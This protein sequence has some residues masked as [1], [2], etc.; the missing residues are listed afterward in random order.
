MLQMRNNDADTARWLDMI[1]ENTER[2][3]ALVQQVLTFARGMSGD[4]VSVS[5]KHVI[6][7]IISV[8]GQ[9]LPKSISVTR[10]IPNELWTISADPTQIHQVLTNICINARDA[11]PSGGTINISANNVVLD[12]DYS[13]MN[14]D[15]APGPYVIVTITD[16][17][18]GMTQDIVKRIFDPFFTTKEVGKGTGLGLSTAITIVKS[19]GGFI[20][21]YSEIGKG[22]QF[23]LYFP[24]K[25]DSAGAEQES[26]LPIVQDGR[27]ELILLVDDEENIRE[28]SR[29][30]LERAGYRVLTAADGTEA[31]AMYVENRD[32][33]ALVVS[34]ISMPIMDGPATIRA[35]R[36]LD[37]AVKVV[38]M[39]GLMNP[40]Q[41][42]EIGK[43]GVDASLSKPFTAQTLHETIGSILKVS[44]SGN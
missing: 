1:R 36:K 30:A 37:P 27:G 24:A 8:L 3:A 26:M 11:M 17:G 21:V 12:E 13:R 5:V 35:L 34:D 44:G 43:L 25:P 39:S 7:D 4:R 14:I 40:E 42:A 32:E 16:T 9:T 31:I 15:A 20:N 2:G 18:T 33:I 6:K 10:D 38:A 23:T 41:T 29:A 28:V 22:T 19:H